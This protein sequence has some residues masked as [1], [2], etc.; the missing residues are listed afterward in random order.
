MKTRRVMGSEN[1]PWIFAC[2]C[3]IVLF[4]YEHVRSP[5]NAMLIQA[6]GVNSIPVAMA[7][8]PLLAVPTLLFYGWLMNRWGPARTLWVSS[9]LSGFALL[10]AYMAISRGFSWACWAL[11]WLRECY[12][13]L[14]LEQVWSFLNSFW[15]EDKASRLNGYVLAVSSIGTA[16]GAYHVSEQAA[17][18]GSHALILVAVGS[19][20]G[21]GV[22]AA[23]AYRLCPD[24]EARQ[25]SDPLKDMS[26]QE[27]SRRSIVQVFWQNKALGWILLLVVTSQIHGT[28]ATVQF[29]TF[30]S[31]SLSTVDAQVA[32]S[33]RFFSSLAVTSIVVQLLLSRP[34]LVG[35]GFGKV[36]LLIPAIHFVCLLW[37]M[38]A[39][40]LRSAALCLF[41]FKAL[42]Y[43]LFRAAKEILYIPFDFEVRYR[44]KEWIDIL[45][46]RGGKVLASSVLLGL[47]ALNLA[48]L[49]PFC[50]L[51]CVC[52]WGISVG[53]LFIWGQGKGEAFDAGMISQ[54]KS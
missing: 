21:F 14:L 29:Q 31:E 10:G 17:A 46:Y 3:A 37:A 12:I 9:T 44:A 28:F 41:T 7:M 11:Y 50:G 4:G 30:L 47:Q 43:S 48:V 38:Y 34:L 53:Y 15:D 33:G 6:Y 8:L 36:H 13:L 32:Y 27:R 51:V 5:S 26:Q 52:L 18:W 25:R 2:A 40:D 42:D 35:F 23:W 16:L 24:F 19:C 45:G 20:F 1:A 39:M 22:V 49:V 54:T